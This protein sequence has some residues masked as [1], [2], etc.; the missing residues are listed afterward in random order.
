[1]T[2]A[3]PKLDAIE[4]VRGRYGVL[5]FFSSDLVVGRSLAMYGEWAENEI[6]FLKTFIRPGDTVLDVGA[7][8]GTHTLA[9]AHAVGASGRVY[10]FEPR[11]EIFGLLEAAV[12]ANGLANVTARQAAVG[13]SEGFLSAPTLHTDDS[14]N[15]GALSLVHE[16]AQAVAAG[17]AGEGDADAVP[18]TTIDALGLADCRL[19]KIDVEGAEP[20]VLE[21]ARDTIARFRPVLYA[22]CNSV[23]IALA[24]K[25]FYDSIG[26][27][28]SM[29]LADAFNADNFLGGTDN[30]F[31]EAREAALLGLHPDA[32]MPGNGDEAGGVLLPVEDADDIAFALL[33]KPQFFREALE[34]TLAGRRYQEVTGHRGDP[35]YRIEKTEERAVAIAD[36]RAK[37]DADRSR[38]EAE[39]AKA[40]AERRQAQEALASANTERYRLAGEC[41]RAQSALAT[42]KAERE[43]LE[44]ERQI[45]HEGI[46]QLEARI[47]LDTQGRHELL[48]QL[49]RMSR[50]PWRPFTFWLSYCALKVLA[51]GTKP[52]SSKT[53]EKF[54]RSA[55]KRNPRRFRKILDAER[56]IEQG[57]LI[58][59]N[60]S[61]G[62]GVP[63]VPAPED[64][65][66]EWLGNAAPVIRLVAAWRHPFNRRKRKAYRA[67]IFNY[68]PREVV[69]PQ[70]VPVAPAPPAAPQ[71]VL[72]PAE[73]LPDTY[74]TAHPNLEGDDH[75][76]LD[77]SVSVVIPTYNAGPEFELLLRKLRSQKGL[78]ALEIVIVDSESKDGT[79]RVAAAFD[80]N[81]VPIKQSEFS[82][83][84]SRNRGAA[85]ASGD[86][87]VFMVQDAYPIG[88]RWLYGLVRCLI[89]NQHGRGLA[90]LSCAEYPRSDS[91]LFYDVLLKGHYDFIGCSEGDRLGEYVTDDHMSLRTQG[92][93]SD[94]ACLIPKPLFDQYKYHGDY[95]E[96][97]TLG[98]KLI[99][100]GYRVAMLSSIRVV[101]S[102]NRPVQYYLRRSFVDVVFLTGIF[103]D[104]VP[105]PA[106]DLEGSLAAAVVLSNLSPELTP[107]PLRSP[108]DALDAFVA[109][110]R[111]TQFP[112]TIADRWDGFGFKPL[113]PWLESFYAQPGRPPALRPSPEIIPSFEQMRI[114]FADRL[115]SLKPALSAYPALDETVC[116]EL[117]DAI[118]KTLAMTIGSQLSFC[119]IA[120]TQDQNVEGLGERLAELRKI[121]TAGV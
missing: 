92:Q 110:V 15:F 34:P 82:H 97:L 62:P 84:Y 119:C 114:M 41:R 56:R 68:Y 66:K 19:I 65:L 99:R 27:R 40:D 80:C 118:I 35:E 22:E 89:D 21:G 74:I 7:N 64:G 25:R 8:I 2:K 102:H 46:A 28:S 36:D 111:G 23:E 9:F 98:V 104:F 37:V 78:R 63:V 20:S 55:A 4:T 42:T 93:L 94:V 107:D 73:P 11:A 79:A 105:P 31:G 117:A 112:E 87:L 17:A 50:R 81:V 116:R 6:A 86:Y 3:K 14:V 39:R 91:E 12:T 44:A 113:Q 83:S 77:V 52:F 100:D 1:M 85:A 30:V 95:A 58:V 43:R 51:A 29:H 16:M 59:S 88:D 60:S 38:I 76:T 48:R 108:L 45:A 96:D 10:A 47:S 120:P 69:A 32:V 103:S 5:S 61:P 13:A 33:Q 71:R 67:S 18:M 57:K 26:Y 54:K 109:R 90:A 75:P 115:A 53:S 72:P 121:L 106:N 49:D 101:H 24:I 70:E